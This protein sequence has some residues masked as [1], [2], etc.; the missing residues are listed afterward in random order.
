M[1]THPQIIL[2]KGIHH[3]Q[4]VIFV[5]FD[6]N[7]ELKKHLREL[8]PAMWSKTYNCWYI[9]ESDFNLNF[10]FV[11]FSELAYID[12]S[13][14]KK[15]LNKVLQP[16]AR[17]DYTYRN[18]IKLP[19]PYSDK[20]IQKRYSESTQRTYSAYFKD[21]LH[22]FRDA[23]INDLSKDDINDYMLKLVAEDKISASEQNQ[24]INAIK[25]YYEKI[26]ERE[27]F[28]YHI[29]RPRRSRQLPKVLSKSEVKEIIKQCN[30][31]KH[32]CILSLIYS[33]GLRRSELI[34]L[35]VTEIYSERR[36]IKIAD[37]KGNK[38]RYTLLS[39]ALL[40]MLRDYYKQFR[41][42]FWLFEGNTNGSQYSATSIAN[43]LKEAARKARIYRRVTPHMLRHSFA[44]HLLEQGTDLRYIQELLGHSSTK[45][46]E[47]YTHVTNKN[48]SNIKNPL[49]EL[50]NDST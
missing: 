6:Y 32:K 15:P 33:A 34:N 47:I 41:P 13:E 2:Q 7:K 12:Y 9:K 14:L 10:F 8:T 36:L 42:K 22:F 50:F 23:D 17:R 30:N 11:K 16:T 28:L 43:I 1:N 5:L 4:Q 37:A 21:F 26:L 35:K 20:L 3:A 25:F 27:K 38:D 39:D 31:L 40:N 24:R 29:D 45:T 48:I 49:D 18:N 19:K 44:T 46:T